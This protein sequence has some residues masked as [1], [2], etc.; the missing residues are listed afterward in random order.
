MHKVKKKASSLMSDE[1]PKP[2][3]PPARPANG[4]PPGPPPGHPSHQSF[5]PPNYDEV[6]ED[7]VEHVPAAVEMQTRHHE[8]V[9]YATIVTDDNDIEHGRIQV[10]SASNI[11]IEIPATERPSRRATPPPAIMNVSASSA[12]SLE[13]QKD[14]A[15][16]ILSAGQNETTEEDD[17][18]RNH[19]EVVH[20]GPPVEHV[21][22]FLTEL[23]SE[24]HALDIN[25][26]NSANLPCE[27]GF[28]RSVRQRLEIPS[29]MLK[30][31]LL[32][33]ESVV[34]EFDYYY[35]T[36]KKYKSIITH[37]KLAVFS[38]GLYVLY[39]LFSYISRAIL[40]FIGMSSLG[41]NRGKMV[42][43][44]KGRLI[45]WQLTAQQSFGADGRAFFKT[46]QVT[47]IMHVRDIK[48]S[49]VRFSRKPALF[50]YCSDSKT[51]LE[52][53]L[54]S[55]PYGR[56]EYSD[57][58][59]T[60]P[61][62][63]FIN[64]VHST[65]GA[66]SAFFD[67]HLFGKSS[68]RSTVTQLQS[69]QPMILRL[70]SKKG[71]SCFAGG[72]HGVASFEAVLKLNQKLAAHLDR[73][74]VFCSPSDGVK[75]TTSEEMYDFK[76][77]EDTNEVILPMS[78][79]PLY[80]G[81]R[82]ITAIGQSYKTTAGDIWKSVMTLGMYYFW[83]L[84]EKQ[85][86]RVANVL[87]N[88][89]IIE[90]WYKSHEGRVPNSLANHVDIRVRSVFP[91]EVSSGFVSGDGKS[92]ITSSILST[93]G[94][95]T[96]VLP[97][98]SNGAKFAEFVQ[99]VTSRAALNLD[100]KA[101][102]GLS[103]LETA[104]AA[105]RRTSVGAVQDQGQPVLNFE[106]HVATLPPE[107]C[108]LLPLLKNEKVFH[109]FDTNSLGLG[110]HDGGRLA[111]SSRTVMRISHTPFGC[112]SGNHRKENDSQNLSSIVKFGAGAPVQPFFVVW[113]PASHVNG[114][115]LDVRS[116]G[117]HPVRFCCSPLRWVAPTRTRERFNL[118]IQTKLG[119]TLPLFSEH[120]SSNSECCSCCSQGKSALSKPY[121]QDDDLNELLRI[122]SLIQDTQ[123]VLPEGGAGRV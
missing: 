86:E 32:N 52:V 82:V 23:T 15:A 9:T 104:R 60:S 45:F 34:G 66:F 77:V 122:I 18:C 53:I 96:I 39:V 117:A 58:F 29:E 112:C 85:K 121:L 5:N 21:A 110:G 71:D 3:P 38:L 2:P 75:H 76:I 12:L 22:S 25:S 105:V 101:V 61:A 111:I 6:V 63:E 109:Y 94:Q 24:Q 100:V 73:T 8:Q 50:C 54:N 1:P 17:S 28:S 115:A 68:S 116:E 65:S 37:I 26:I 48:E 42:V 11:Q 120:R 59:Y 103:Y 7:D 62:V 69:A 33:E 35:P 98:T 83:T 36:P 70:V 40:S 56:K 64:A 67:E 102:P 90:I 16:A 49:T 81:E 88:S 4:P 80:E 41:S 108:Q 44:S 114:Q 27:D 79:I 13:S 31:L 57:F 43:T 92:S 72:D 20:D 95:F 89:R 87:T 119:L 91:G 51:S 84:R 97:L 14:N 123:E 106:G 78:Y 55:F 99:C 46:A 113:I 118:Q 107:L 93:A 19:G 47:R 10:L 30:R 74:E